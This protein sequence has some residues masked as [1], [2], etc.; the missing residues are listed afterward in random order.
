MARARILLLPLFLAVALTSHFA[1]GAQKTNALNIALTKAIR[2]SDAQSVKAL[3]NKGA[4]ANARDDEGATV[5]MQAALNA[6]A[7]CLR[8]LLDKGADPNAR[9]K[10]GATA[11]MWAVADI[12]K[13]NLLLSK[14]ADTKA[15]AASGSTALMSAAAYNGA[16]DVVRV[17]IEH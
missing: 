12:R 11:L 5:L 10:A 7:D 2:D 4:D 16:A 17:L 9:N 3:L 13:I 14:G 1:H 15:K 8:L 6:D